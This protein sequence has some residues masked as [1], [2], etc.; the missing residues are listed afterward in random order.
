MSTANGH[1]GDV[2]FR[3]GGEKHILWFGWSGI[4]LLQE[5]LGTEFDVRINQAIGTL[6]LQV[7]AK[8]LAIGLR[9]SWPGVTAEMVIDAS[10]PIVSATEAIALGMKRTFHGMGEVPALPDQNPPRGR[11]PPALA[12]ILFWRD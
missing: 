9:N 6:D 11:L 1:R 7:L 8:T 10:P 3:I 4:A 12:K 2:P 5:I